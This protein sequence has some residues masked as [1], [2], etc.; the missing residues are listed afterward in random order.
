MLKITRD[1][2]TFCE[3]SGIENLDIQVAIRKTSLSIN[4]SVFENNPNDKRVL[5]VVLD[6]FFKTL[7]KQC[8]INSWNITKKD[9][10]SYLIHLTK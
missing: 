4:L 10:N 9:E 2:L 5:E 8:F 7:K 6:T 1:L 3:N